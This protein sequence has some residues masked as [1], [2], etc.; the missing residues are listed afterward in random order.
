M[1]S[2]FLAIIAISAFAATEAAAAG[3]S[4]M[5]CNH[6]PTCQ[7]ARNAGNCNAA[8]AAGGT[9]PRSGGSGKTGAEC[10]RQAGFTQAQWQ[11]GQ[12]TQAQ[13][14]AWSKCMGR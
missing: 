5:V 11:A 9:M 2:I 14:R 1:K 12:T 6:N 3:C 13:R 4:Q 7:A 10:Q 8:R